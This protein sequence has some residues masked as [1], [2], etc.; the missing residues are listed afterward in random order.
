MFATRDQ[1][2]VIHGHQQ[3]AASKP[4]ANGT[5]GLQP[6]TPGNRHVKTPLKVPLNDEN[7]VGGFAGRTQGGDK[8]GTGMKKAVLDKHAFITPM[9]PS[10][11]DSEAFLL[12]WLRLHR[13]TRTSTSRSE[14]YKCECEATPDTCGP[15]S[16]G[17]RQDARQN[18]HATKSQDC[19]SYVK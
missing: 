14:D 2:N 4:L 3:L 1:E 19:I 6:K 18:K 9:G 12:Q 10:D 13:T 8:F 17:G 11:K 5:R 7:A 16:Q 15:N